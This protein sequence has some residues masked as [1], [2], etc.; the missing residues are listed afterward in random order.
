MEDWSAAAYGERWAAAY[1]ELHAEALRPPY[2]DVE[3]A[4][5]LLAELAAGGRV[6]ELAVGT[7]RVALP[8]AARGCEG[9]RYQSRHGRAPTGQIGRRERAGRDRRHGGRTRRRRVPGHLRRVQLAVRPAVA[10]GAGSLRAQRG[11]PS[12]SRRG[13][14]G[15]SVRPRSGAPQPIQADQR[16]RRRPRPLRNGAS[17]ELRP[18]KLRYIWPAEL[19]LMAELAGLRLRDR[20]SD[21][22]RSPFSSHSPVPHLG[23]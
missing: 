17:P 5:D 4:L 14:R 9:C 8:L 23:L 22:R 18:I 11:R 1:D 2:G 21:W 16:A 10:G 6:L 3:G 15:R 13:I 19:D 20:W 7:G 12:D